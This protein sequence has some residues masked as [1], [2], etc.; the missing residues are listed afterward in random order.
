MREPAS[1][2]SLIHRRILA[3]R[4]H[5]LKVT[6]PP[7]ALHIFGKKTGNPFPCGQPSWL[8]VST[9]PDMIAKSEFEAY[10]PAAALVKRFSCDY[11]I[12][13]KRLMI[14]LLG[15]S[16]SALVTLGRIFHGVLNKFG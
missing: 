8:S 16:I 6:R 3:R 11:T 13:N 1:T 4:P 7:Q 15:D 5:T 12:F 2:A 14:V 9:E 10:R